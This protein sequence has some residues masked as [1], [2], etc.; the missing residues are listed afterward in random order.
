MKKNLVIEMEEECISCPNLSLVTTKLFTDVQDHVWLVHNCEHL[1][2]C[3]A[4]RENWEK[5]KNRG[6]QHD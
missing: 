2:F 3:K 6:G 5:V 4:V 1:N